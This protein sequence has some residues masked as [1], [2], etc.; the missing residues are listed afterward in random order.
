MRGK[1]EKPGKKARRLHPEKHACPRR[2][3][4]EAT[5]ARFK[6]SPSRARWQ[7]LLGRRTV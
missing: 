1:E 7:S 4:T 2:E 3:D 5:G 6:P